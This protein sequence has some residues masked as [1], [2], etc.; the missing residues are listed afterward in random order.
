MANPGQESPD[1]KTLLKLYGSTVCN[2]WVMGVLTVVLV[3]LTLILVFTSFF[4][5]EPGSA[6]SKDV[7]CLEFQDSM[8]EVGDFAGMQTRT[9]IFYSPREKSCL[10]IGLDWD[11]KIKVIDAITDNVIHSVELG[12]IRTENVGEEVKL[13][14]SEFRD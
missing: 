8:R 2:T 10:Y 11:D 12:Q 7:E 5:R 3:V 6:V 4:K 1:N 9:G 13:L 14:T